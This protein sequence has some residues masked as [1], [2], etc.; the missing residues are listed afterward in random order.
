MGS[1]VSLARCGC[2][3][4]VACPDRESE[5]SI[6]EQ[7]EGRG[8]VS[9]P[10]ANGRSPSQGV[11]SRLRFVGSSSASGRCFCHHC[12]SFFSLQ[13][14]QRRSDELRCAG[15]QSA[16]IEM[17]RPT[18]WIR[19]S[20]SVG[21]RFSFEDSLDQAIRASL[22]TA[23]PDRPAKSSFVR[24]LPRRAVE[25]SD[26]DNCEQCTF[27]CEDFAVGSEETFLPCQHFF[28]G[29]CLEQWL[30]KRNSCPV[31]RHAL[32]EEEDDL[33]C[34]PPAS[35]NSAAA[36]NLPAEAPAIAAN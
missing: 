27:C 31:C 14:G 2:R 12:Q 35:A 28:H 24:G 16:F 1:A 36:H 25:Q 8:V 33:P 22:E 7:G 32:P 26:L 4:P 18:A 30:Q 23:V 34:V 29:K 13:A 20:S 15:C 10:H 19:P 6:N 11:T 5:S 9:A 21:R 17:P 3:R